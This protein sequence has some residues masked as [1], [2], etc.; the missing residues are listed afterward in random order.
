MKMDILKS[1]IIKHIKKKKDL[2]EYKSNFMINIYSLKN[3]M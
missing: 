1:I 3:Q 2:Y